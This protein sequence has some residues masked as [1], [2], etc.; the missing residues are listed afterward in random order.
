MRH[1]GRLAHEL[2][3]GWGSIGR[4]PVMG[5]P[6]YAGPLLFLR[7][8]GNQTLSRLNAFDL[9]VTVSLGST[10]PTII[11]SRQT[12]VACLSVRWP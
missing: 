4:V 2:F 7:L 5:L 8:S 11:V 12:G 3:R 9:V 6:T 1:D 10:L